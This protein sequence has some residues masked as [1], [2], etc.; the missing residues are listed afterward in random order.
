MSHVTNDET[1]LTMGL[2]A[3][4]PLNCSKQMSQLRE[5]ILLC[6][7]LTGEI[8]VDSF[9]IFSSRSLQQQRRCLFIYQ[10]QLPGCLD[11]SVRL[12]NI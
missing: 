5:D 1:Q 9:H 8:S 12:G 7:K 11:D 4:E 3:E 10:A 2:R 6:H